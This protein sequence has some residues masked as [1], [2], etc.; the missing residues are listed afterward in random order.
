MVDLADLDEQILVTA[1]N[2]KVDIVVWIKLIKLSLLMKTNKK[3]SP[4]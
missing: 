2:R 4:C 3:D 1:G